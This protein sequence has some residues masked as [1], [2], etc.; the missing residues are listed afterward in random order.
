[1]EWARRKKFDI[2]TIQEAHI[3]KEDINM[4]KDVW[5]G[6]I[7]YSSGSNN[8]RGVAILI[9]ENLEH[10]VIAEKNDNNGRWQIAKIKM[11]GTTITIANY[12]GPND[13]NPSHLEDMINE[14]HKIEP[15]KLI[16]TGDYNLVMNID[17]DKKGG[18]PR[19]NFKCQ[20]L[21]KS[22]MEELE[23]SDIWR[24]KNPEKRV[25][26]W[27]SKTNV[28]VMSRLDFILMSD[29]LQTSHIDSNIIPGYMSD[30][31]CTTLTI[32]VPNGERGKGFWKYN[33]KLSTHKVLK[34][35]IRE[36]IKTTIEENQETDD[37]LMWDL[38]KCKIRG[39]CISFAAKL[40]KEKKDKLNSIEKDIQ[41]LEEKRQTFISTKNEIEQIRIEDRLNM[42]LAER[43]I[44]ITDKVEGDAIR[45]RVSWHEEGHKASKMFLNLEKSRGEAKTIR[46]LKTPE[47]KII[48]GTKE[49]LK[50][51]EEFYRK[52]YKS[53]REKTD[54][55]SIE[56]YTKAR[57]KKLI[58]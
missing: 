51:E 12:Y 43:D 20:K 39:T 47:G 30:H 45:C 1:L 32:K 42:K 27:V 37:C 5:K 41:Q 50:M 17:I 44:L 26:T 46:K 40:N 9:R 16:V 6:N 25:Y 48:S 21:L 31:A 52:I 38:L 53:Q 28:K 8:S 3:M 55:H 14:I 33:S 54:H 18:L 49:I 11:K 7:L 13:D 10:E 29:S 23:L 34:E 19:T 35:Q 2:M 57:E 58:T 36:T 24:I 22:W 15:E 4:W 56:K